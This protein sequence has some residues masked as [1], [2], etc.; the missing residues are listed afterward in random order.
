ML[1]ASLLELPVTHDQC[2]KLQYYSTTTTYS[3]SVNS[4]YESTAVTLFA[5]QCAVAQHG[6]IE[7]MAYALE[8]E[9]V[10]VKQL[11]KELLHLASTNSLE[12]AQWLHAQGAPLARSNSS[13]SSNS[14]VDTQ[15]TV[16]FCKFS[17]VLL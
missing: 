5:I 3:T 4:A 14:S 7:L 11:L 17:R 10:R 13:S 1:V 2:H 12:A 9:P 16:E 6:N 15:V 8:Q